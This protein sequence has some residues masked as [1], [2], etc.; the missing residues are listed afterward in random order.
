MLKEMSP[1]HAPDIVAVPS[2][3]GKAFVRCYLGNFF[4]FPSCNNSP[5][6]HHPQQDCFCRDNCEGLLFSR[7]PTI[8]F[9]AG[10]GRCI[11]VVVVIGTSCVGNTCV[12]GE[13]IWPGV[14]I[15]MVN[16]QDLLKLLD[17]LPCCHKHT[18]SGQFSHVC[19]S[20]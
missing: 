1:T 6:S 11:S 4:E 7:P 17:T 19:A 18:L 5:F 8:L 13:A 16:K 10:I 20:L 14:L 2:L 9:Q 3:K 15:D 12:C